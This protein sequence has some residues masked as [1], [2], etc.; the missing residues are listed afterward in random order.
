MTNYQDGEILG[1]D[2]DGTLILWDA[3]RNQPYNC[4]ETL[5]EFTAHGAKIWD[6][7]MARLSDD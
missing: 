1:I 7:E 5:A 3:E 4:G 6:Y 2:T